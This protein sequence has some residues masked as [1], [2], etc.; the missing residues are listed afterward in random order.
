MTKSL[1]KSERKEEEGHR[2]VTGKETKSLR[3]TYPLFPPLAYLLLL[4]HF[5]KSQVVSEYGFK[6][7]LEDRRTFRLSH[8]RSHWEREQYS[9]RVLVRS[10]PGMVG[11]AIGKTG[12]PS[13]QAIP[14]T[15]R[16]SQQYLGAAPSKAVDNPNYKDLFSPPIPPDSW[17]KEKMPQKDCRRRK[18]LHIP[19]SL[20]RN[21]KT[22]PVQLKGRFKT[23][24]F[25]L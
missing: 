11:R 24:P 17:E 25:C 21:R 7:H 19:K 5:E 1:P 3:V 8:S 15:N 18:R 14:Q 16:E 4:R 20:W 2:K 12:G 10:S 22:D 23:G 6:I 13:F 9:G